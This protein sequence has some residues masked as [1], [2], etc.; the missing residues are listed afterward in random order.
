[1]QYHTAHQCQGWRQN[2]WQCII[3][4]LCKK[5]RSATT[6]MDFKGM[7]T[8]ATASEPFTGGTVIPPNPYIYIHCRNTDRVLDE[9]ICQYLQDA[10]SIWWLNTFAVL[11]IA[12]FPAAASLHLASVWQLG[13]LRTVQSLFLPNN[14]WRLR[15]RFR[16]FATFKKNGG[17]WGSSLSISASDNTICLLSKG[18]D[19]TKDVQL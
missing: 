7:D 2:I 1:M 17:M 10:T 11:Q 5:A 15:L 19:F 6:R 8:K 14:P 4:S 9:F 16:S 12:I 13:D 18:R 3:C